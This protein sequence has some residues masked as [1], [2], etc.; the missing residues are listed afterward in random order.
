MVTG[1]GDEHIAAEAIQRGA[2]DYLVKGKEDIALLPSMIVK[3]IHICEMYASFERSLEKTRYQALLLSNVRDAIVVWDLDGRITY[4]NPAAQALFGW[5]PDEVLGTQVQETYLAM[6]SPQTSLPDIEHTSGFETERLCTTKDGREVWVS[7]RAAVLRD[8]G[9]NNQVI[10]TIDVVRNITERKQM[11][12]QI[13]SAQNQLVQAAR[14]AA[15]GE[16]ASGVAHQINNP[17]TTIIAETQIL[18]HEISPEHPAR[19]SAQAIEKAGWRVHDAVQLLLQF[20]KP[21][22]NT[23]EPNSVNDAIQDAI[24]LVGEKVIAS[25]VRLVTQLDSDLPRVICNARQLEDL[26]VNLILAAAAACAGGSEHMIQISSHIDESNQV[27]VEVFDNGISIPNDQLDT[28]FK[29]NFI[30]STCGRGNGLEY[31]ICQEIIRHMDGKIWV[32]CSL[33]SGTIIEVL[34]PGCPKTNN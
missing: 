17:L 28:I 23:L 15:F 16:L 1:Q 7:S 19:E 20:S 21:A 10:G 14:L 3:S 9:V 26:W 18:L 22:S 12:A 32:K 11:E 8:Y 5:S 30:G 24:K 31:S 33:E 29:P 25:G 13:Q 27:V 6:F 34:L 2:I 4:W